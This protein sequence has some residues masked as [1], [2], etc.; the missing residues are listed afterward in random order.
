LSIYKHKRS[1]KRIKI[2]VRRMYRCYEIRCWCV[3]RT[4]SWDEKIV[5]WILQLL[6]K[7]R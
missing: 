2:F 5:L 7:F 3:C 4:G 1:I 6:W